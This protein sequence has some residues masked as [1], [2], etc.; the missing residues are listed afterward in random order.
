MHLRLIFIN[1]FF[2]PDHSATSQMLTDLVFGLAKRGAQITVITSGSV[3]MPPK[4]GSRIAK[5]PRASMLFAFGLR[6]SVGS[7]CFLARSTI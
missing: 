1:R 3:T 2:Y 5:R 7:F 6:A 4:Y